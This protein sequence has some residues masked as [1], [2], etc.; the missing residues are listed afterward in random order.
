MWG[1]FS[2]VGKVFNVS[3]SVWKRSKYGFAVNN[4]V[5]GAREPVWARQ[6]SR[7]GRWNG[8]GAMCPNLSPLNQTHLGASKEGE[9]SWKCET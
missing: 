2:K 7:Q 4:V 5:V 3:D 8:M 6:V 9:S 1:S